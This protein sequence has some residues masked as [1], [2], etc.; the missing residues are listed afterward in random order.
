MGNYYSAG[1]N[2][3]RMGNYP[4]AAGGIFGSIFK[5][6]KKVGGALLGVTPVGRA[7]SALSAVVPGF[8][9]GFGPGVE[10]PKDM[11]G[12]IK[13][14][15][16]EGAISRFLPFGSTGYILGRRKRMNVANAKALRRAIRRQRGFIKLAKRALRGTGMSIG[17]RG[18]GGKKKR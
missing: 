10:V 14:P 1:D 4:Y 2:Y 15:G 7:A 17:M 16:A 5:G 6:I 18:R 3:G 9:Q 11:P 13:K 8:G 12:A